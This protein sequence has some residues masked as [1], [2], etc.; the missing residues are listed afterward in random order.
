MKRILVVDDEKHIVDHLVRTVEQDL[1][2]GFAVVATAA[3]AREALEK[4]ASVRPDIVVM[5]VRMPG[6]SGL[7]AIREM[8]RRGVEAAF[9]LSTAYERFDIVRDAL[10]LGITGYLLK[11]VVRDKLAEALAAAA[12]AVD[13]RLEAEA[14]E[15]G[16]RDRELREGPLAA[17]AFFSALMLG[18][19]SPSVLG[20]LK[21][22]LSAGWNWVLVGA[23]VYTGR[24]AEN[25]RAL[26]AA[27]SYKS[28]ALVGPLVG[29]RAA[30]ALPLEAP[31][32]EVPAAGSL[33]ALAAAAVPEAWADGLVRLGFAG[34]RPWEDLDS[35]WAE[36]L[37]RLSGAGSAE[38]VRTFEV[39]EDFHAAL[40]KADFDGVAAAL[41]TLLE[42]LEP[43]VS[44]G[45]TDRY[46]VIVLLGSALSRLVGLGRLDAGTAGLGMNFD[47]LRQASDGAEFCL[48]AR[49]RLPVIAAA[50]ARGRRWSSW[51]AAA[52]EHIRLH[53]G[54][55]LTLESVADQVGLTPKK[56]SRLFIEETGQGFSD[57][58]I[59]FRIGKAK[60]LLSAS[61][62]SIK[63]VSADCGYP[64][65]NYFSRL[66]KKVTGLTPSEF[67][68]QV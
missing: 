29:R 14:R 46:R 65:P 45:V 24:S 36:A 19:I 61:G 68:S 55:A 18:R 34:P 59:D 12:E 44:P 15:A 54:Q 51:M 23:V 67:S 57:Y 11:P 26:E 30:V 47:D 20:T 42:V 22:R 49:A 64:D 40:L 3:S 16:Y 5:D 43:V 9:I 50:L 1:A 32:H 10:E 66:F 52:L 53:Y 56:L 33:M 62:A 8:K 7:D 48:A 35:S 27:F 37:S 58:L 17:E 31:D 25:H 6:L 41:E 13:R 63:Q 2:G 38:A 4:V 60:T 21:A 39:E 28:R